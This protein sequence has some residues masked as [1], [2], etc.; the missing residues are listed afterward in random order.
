MTKQSTLK[1]V[2]WK[3]TQKINSRYQII[4][5]G[6]LKE[7]EYFM[8][9]IYTYKHKFNTEKKIEII[10]LKTM[11]YWVA[12]GKLHGGMEPTEPF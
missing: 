10:L 11:I 4:Q 3:C 6:T 7:M 9:V 1:T 5:W 2:L 8:L 12:R